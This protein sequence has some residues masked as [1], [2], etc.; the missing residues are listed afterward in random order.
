[1][2]WTGNAEGCACLS[3]KQQSEI[4][5]TDRTGHAE[6]HAHLSDEQN[7]ERHVHHDMNVVDEEKDSCDYC[8]C[9]GISVLIRDTI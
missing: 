9:V 8:H 7:A 5:Q 1:M 3:W 2:D 4:W 6:G